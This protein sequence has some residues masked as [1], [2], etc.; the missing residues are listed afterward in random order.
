MIAY[1]HVLSMIGGF[2]AMIVTESIIWQKYKN[3]N[4]RDFD[5]I[6]LLFSIVTISLVLLWMTGVVLIIISYVDD[7]NYITNQKIWAKVVIVSVMTLN[8]IYIARRIMPKIRDLQSQSTLVDTQFESA[9]FRF[10]F[11][12]SWS[13]WMLTAFFGV[14]RFM[15]HS[16]SIFST[17]NL[18]ILIVGIMFIAS[19]IFGSAGFLCPPK[20]KTIDH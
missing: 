3:F 15:N 1:I 12:I 6:R 11:A 17:L 8:G 9:M 19:Y 4:P 10:S 20:N 14:A 5:N 2:T 18:Y 16:Y 7:P 13:G